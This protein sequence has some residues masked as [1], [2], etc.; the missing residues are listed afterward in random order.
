[1]IDQSSHRLSTILCK[2]RDRET[3][4]SRPNDTLKGVPRREMAVADVEEGGYLQEMLML[5]AGEA[6]GPGLRVDEELEHRRGCVF[7][8]RLREAVTGA[9]A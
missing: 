2:R 3:P 7:V 8:S 5:T 1:M 4:V 9:G 6:C